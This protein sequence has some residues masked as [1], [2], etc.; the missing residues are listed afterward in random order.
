MALAHPVL[1]IG[2][3]RHPLERFLSLLETAQVTAVAD[4]RSA[5][6][7]RFSPH[8]NK[9][10][11]AA[12]LAAQDIAYVFLGMELGGR[13]QRQGA[14]REDGRLGRRRAS[15]CG[16]RCDVLEA[17]EVIAQAPRA[18]ERMLDLENLTEAGLL[19][20]SPEE[21][22]AEAYR[23]RGRKVAYARQ[24]ASSAPRGGTARQD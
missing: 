1:T 23:L 19:L 22:L 4:I 6:V 7:S 13:P 2:H 10:A 18:E 16:R 11:L 8:F 21:R 12:S 5:P 15:M 14:I 20:R 3:S 9:K 17:G 24:A